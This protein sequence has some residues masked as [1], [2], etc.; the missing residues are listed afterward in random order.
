MIET[1]NFAFLLSFILLTTNIFSSEFRLTTTPEQETLFDPEIEKIEF[2]TGDALDYSSDESEYE[3]QADEP[4]SELEKAE[5]EYEELNNKYNRYLDY[6]DWLK[7]R[8]DSCNIYKESSYNNPT[9]GKFNREIE[10]KEKELR[11]A[12]ELYPKMLELIKLKR[13]AAYDKLLANSE[14]KYRNLRLKLPTLEVTETTDAQNT[15][16]SEP[17]APLFG[18]QNK[19]CSW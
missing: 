3:S 2:N 6:K 8:I 7:Q 15:D 5:K 17:H 11:M 4:V 1:K 10:E 16:Y 19:K 18:R 9:T 12:Q 14:S 13:D